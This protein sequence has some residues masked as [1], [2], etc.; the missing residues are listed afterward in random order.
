[1]KRCPHRA[2][3]LAVLAAS[4]LGPYVPAAAQDDEAREGSLFARVEEGSDGR[5][6]ALQMAIVSYA[7]PGREAV[8]VDLVGAVHIGDAAYYEALNRQFLDYDA[9]LYELIAPP[10]TPVPA[11][12]EMPD[13]FVSSTQ[14]AL[15]TALG[16]A[17]QLEAIDYSAP[18]FVHADLSPEELRAHMQA[19]GESFYVYF[20]RAFYAAMRD[21]SRDPL[22]LRDLGLLATLLSPGGEDTLKVTMAYELASFDSVSSVLDGPDGSALIASRNQRAIDVL[23]GKLGDGV[24]RVGIFYGVAHMPDMERR[25][26]DQLGL[27]PVATR[28]VDA[29]LLDETGIP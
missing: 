2:L 20:W 11:T 4:L 28:W 17:F 27:E 12:G 19:R 29:W 9:V 7:L 6:R 3:L 8:T 1:L 18:N 5:P 21:A 26:R 13:S 16:L 25:L 14:M 22:G 23:A 24:T 10:G 15:R